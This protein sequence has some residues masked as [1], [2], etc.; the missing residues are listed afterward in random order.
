MYL[1]VLFKKEQVLTLPKVLTSVSLDSVSFFFEVEELIFFP[2]RKCQVR[3]SR[4]VNG[5]ELQVLRSSKPTPTTQ[6]CQC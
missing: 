1:S 4:P 5:L 6:R 2:W 3:A